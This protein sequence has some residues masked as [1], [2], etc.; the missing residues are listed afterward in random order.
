[1]LDEVA[2]L[3]HGHL[4]RLRPHADDHHVAADGAALA[5]PT[6][7]FLER[8]VVELEGVAAQNG[9]DGLHLGRRGV[10]AAALATAAA[11]T[12][13]TSAASA[14]RL[15]LGGGFR[16]GSG[17]RVTDL[18]LADERAIGGL[19]RLR[20]T[21]VR[22][23]GQLVGH[24][25]GRRRPRAL[26]AVSVWLLPARP[27]TCRPRCR[28]CRNHPRRD[29]PNPRPVPGPRP[30]P[31][32]PR[33]PRRRRDLGEPVCSAP[34]APAGV[35]SDAFGAGAGAGVAPPLDAS[36][37]SLMTGSVMMSVPSHD[38]RSFACGAD[39]ACSGSRLAPSPVLVDCVVIH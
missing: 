1:M 37:L 39:V 30:R 34:S 11:P 5:V 12:T 13:A 3:E 23:L 8:V 29:G 35:A 14:L 26:P 36:S 7:P 27:R 31:R 10:V 15:G 6:S 18:R 19:G 32:P 21:L 17:T 20:T 25:V 4:R 22:S 16:G 33:E 28:G 24:L 38:A 2:T 9:F